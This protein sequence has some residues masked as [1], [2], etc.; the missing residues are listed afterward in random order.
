MKTAFVCLLFAFHFSLFAQNNDQWEFKGEKDGIKLYHRKS[1]GFLHIKLSTSIKVPLSGIVALFSDV[2]HYKDWGYKMSE[3]R[4]LKRV[5]SMENWYYARYDFPWPLDDRDI[6]LQSKIEQDQKTRKI[7]ILNTPYPAY[8]PENKGVE[9]IKNTTT[10]WSF[11]PGESG[12]VYVEQ[13]ITT[14]SAEGMPDWLINMTVDTGPRETARA[15][16][17]LLQQEKYQTARLAYVKE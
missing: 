16:R 15:V 17:N 12:W 9:R 10:R 14:D 11:S 1:P 5:S 4:L 6:I 13:E 7:S 3:S 2:D 8:L